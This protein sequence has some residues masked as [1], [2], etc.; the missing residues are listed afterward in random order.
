LVEHAFYDV[1][2][3]IGRSL[4]NKVMGATGLA[5]N[6]GWLLDGVMNDIA[7]LSIISD[8]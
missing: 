2:S 4:L 7:F 6:V 1:L 8:V 5:Q 3:G